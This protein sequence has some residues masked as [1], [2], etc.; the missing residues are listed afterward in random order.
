MYSFL[1]LLCVLKASL[2]ILLGYTGE[3]KWHLDIRKVKEYFK[4]KNKWIP[5]NALVSNNMI[6]LILQRLFL[7]IVYFLNQYRDQNAVMLKE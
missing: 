7:K 2:L 3:I 6:K 4:I 1:N 5:N